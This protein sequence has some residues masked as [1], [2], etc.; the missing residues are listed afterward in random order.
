MNQFKS[1]LFDTLKLTKF[2]LFKDFYATINYN[3]NNRYF[4]ILSRFNMT[5]NLRIASLFN[6]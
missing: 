2:M 1:L 6:R 3:N 4:Q 5:I